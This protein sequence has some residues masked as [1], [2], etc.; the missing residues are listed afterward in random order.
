MNQKKL[1]TILA[2]V[3]VILTGIT[4]YLASVKNNSQSVVNNNS[5]QQVS[6][7]I[8]DTSMEWK[9]YV[10]DKHGYQFQYPGDVE[11]VKEA[12]A[13]EFEPGEWDN[14]KIIFIDLKGFTGNVTITSPD[15]DKNKNL[16]RCKNG[17]NAIASVPETKDIIDHKKL[18]QDIEIDGQRYDLDIYYTKSLYGEYLLS[19]AC[20]LDGTVI[21]MSGNMGNWNMVRQIVESYRKSK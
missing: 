21:D 8:E 10:N 19:I 17:L 5:T 2:V 18:F 15:V 12:Q 1:I 9:T 7:K 4:I 13:D 6:N 14:K 16:S 11:Y 20:L 3:I